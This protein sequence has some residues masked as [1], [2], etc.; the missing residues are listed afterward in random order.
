[1]RIAA[2]VSVLLICVAIY[3]L[4]YM[5]FMRHN[6]DSTD[7]LQRPE[8]VEVLRRLERIEDQVHKIGEFALF[9]IGFLIY[10]KMSLYSLRYYFF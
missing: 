4:V 5:T 8:D 3:T 1:M 2:R 6:E 10:N 7:M 9:C